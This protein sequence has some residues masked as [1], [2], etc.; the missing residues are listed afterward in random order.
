MG[1][2]LDLI[3]NVCEENPNVTLK[4]IK[5][6]LEAYYGIKK[7]QK[8][9][10]EELAIITI[11]RDE[12]IKEFNL[13]FKKLINKHTNDKR[14]NYNIYDYIKALKPRRRVWEGLIVSDCNSLTEAYEKAERYDKVEMNLPT[15]MN[16][17][18]PLMNA[19]MISTNRRD[20]QCYN[21]GNWGHIQRFCPYN[22]GYLN[23]PHW[24][25]Y[26]QGYGLNHGHEIHKLDVELGV[27]IKDY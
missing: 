23:R 24:S 11:N 1:D 9:I 15:N 3:K 2:A 21:C 20:R 27:W 25:G 7:N 14:K 4:E 18:D 19:A 17:Y 26:N 6:E 5:D 16:S 10:I 13:K 22:N 12:T 8:N